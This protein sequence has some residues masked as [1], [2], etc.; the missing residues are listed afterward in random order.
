MNTA[1]ATP[2]EDYKKDAQGRL[3]PLSMIRPIDL[4]R[5]AL[6]QEIV[7]KANTL[8]E[9]ISAAKSSFFA[10]IA[11]FVSMSAE[12]YDV[13]IGGEKGNVSLVSYDGRYKVIRAIQETLV[14]DERL[15]AAKA[16][17]DACLQRWSQGA[18]P[19][20]K[21]LINDAFQ[22][23]KSG[24]INTG[25]VLGLRRLPIQDEE[26]Q[27]AMTAIGDALQV[28]GSKSY[29]RIYERIGESGKYRPIP[30][31]MAGD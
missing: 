6:V 4:A 8:A 20:I 3:V 19:E 30:L 17:I 9:Q 28:A 31:D 22:V 2:T 29:V 15:Q 13:K 10:D 7:T 14:F 26:W 1:T 25:R 18:K 24:N 12:E 11:A 21:V 5:D 16:L 23:D 27:N